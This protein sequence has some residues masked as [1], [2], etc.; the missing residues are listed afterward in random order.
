MPRSETTPVAAICREEALAKINL[1]LHVTR[2]RPDGYH[3]LDS[4]VVFAGPGDRV[5]VTPAVTDPAKWNT[6]FEEGPAK[7]DLHV[8]GP[9]SDAL[10]QESDNLVQRA[11]HQFREAFGS[12][13]A[14]LHLQKNL[15]VAAG[16]GGGSA[17]AAAT[18]RALSRLWKLSPEP[19]K[20][21]ALAL[22][23]GA[24]V[25]VCLSQRPVHMSGIG[26][27]LAPLAQMPALHLLLVNPGIALSTPAVFRS[28]KNTEI[29][30]DTG[31]SHPGRFS[32]MD[33][34]T[35]WLRSAGNDLEAPASALV[36]EIGE[37]LHL[38]R[39]QQGCLLARMSGS[40]ATCF[41][42]FARAAD[43]HRAEAVM[44]TAF[45]GGWVQPVEAAAR[46]S[47]PG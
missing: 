25:P 29:R 2:R 23:L 9:F 27:K 35:G 21:A 17:D 4:L 40:G 28:L 32:S 26:E 22:K 14:R 38:L 7:R 30:K 42:L 31:R 16:I 24:D 43:T 8:S 34:L 12:P 37:I 41:G 18:L 19:K 10:A 15:P 3:E 6:V 5:E 46:V 39:R 11:E 20:M 1:S 13:P 33:E 36:P 44:K 47:A 45:A